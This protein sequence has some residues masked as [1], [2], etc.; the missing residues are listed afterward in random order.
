MKIG[1]IKVIKL[2]PSIL[3]A[4][5]SNLIE[6]I[7]R[8]E[9][10][11]ADLLHIDVMDGHFVPNITIGPLVIESIRSKTSL[12]FDVH[13][14]I[15]EPEK[16]IESFVK[17]GAEIITVHAETSYHL[18]RLIYD[19]KNRDVKA[20]IALNPATP[21]SVLDYIM[22][23]VDMILIMSVNPGFGGQKFI[24]YCLDKIR[25]LASLREKNG[26]GFEIEVD[27]GVNLDNLKAIVDAG[28][29]IVVA[30]S[31]IFNSK[32]IQGTVKM[33]KRLGEGRL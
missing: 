1:G 11:G 12:I 4:D 13:L 26:L 28:T 2:A 6:D 22:Y 27:G 9:E 20:G 24:P 33:F 19:I 17:A 25:Q 5:F 29:D 21:L 32:D 23:D 7:K 30:G 8:V 3:S 31:A 15:E 18:N 16:Y 14:M 10:A